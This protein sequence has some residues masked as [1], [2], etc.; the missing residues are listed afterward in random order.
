MI[1]DKKPEFLQAAV[2]YPTRKNTNH[3]ITVSIIS[4]EERTVLSL[5]LRILAYPFSCPRAF[6]R[7]FLTRQNVN[8]K[9]LKMPHSTNRRGIEGR[10]MC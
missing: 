2:G 8:H 3:K 10:E 7:V 1:P 5:E 4:E 6:R 9:I